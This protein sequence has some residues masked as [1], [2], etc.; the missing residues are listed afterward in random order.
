MNIEKNYKRFS[1][2]EFYGFNDSTI[3]S[4]P[5]IPKILIIG[6]EN[7]NKPKDYVIEKVSFY[8]FSASPKSV[9]YNRSYGLISR[10]CVANS[11]KSNFKKKLLKVN[12]RLFY[13]QI[14]IQCLSKIMFQIIK[15]GR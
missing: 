8:N 11:F 2:I 14:L 4:Y 12:I 13:F 5:E 6:R 3:R 1:A 7:N 10:C 9:F 15:R